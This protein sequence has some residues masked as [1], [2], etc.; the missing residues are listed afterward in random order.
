MEGDPQHD[1][2]MAGDELF[3]RWQQTTLI[4][5]P[6]VTGPISL[7]SSTMIAYIIINDWSHKRHHLYHRLL[8]AMSICDMIASTNASFSG[9]YIPKVYNRFGSHGNIATCEM[10]G[11]FMT[12]SISFAVLNMF[13][14]LFYMRVV[15][16]GWTP[17]VISRNH[18]SAINGRRWDCRKIPWFELS[19]YFLS[20][21]YP[22]AVAGAALYHESF[23]PMVTLPGWCYFSEVPYDCNKFDDVPCTRGA[24]YSFIQ[25]FG[26]VIPVGC[27][28]IGGTVAVTMVSRTVRKQCRTMIAR[29]GISSSSSQSLDV[30]TAGNAENSSNRT[31]DPP[32]R[33]DGNSSSDDSS[34]DTSRPPQSRLSTLSRIFGRHQPTP[35]PQPQSSFVNVGRVYKRLHEAA[36]QAWLYSLAF[37]IT[38]AV[39]ISQ[40]FTG[41]FMEAT[42]QNRLFFFTT[43]VLITTFGPLQ[44]AWNLLIYLRPYYRHVR[45]RDPHLSCWKVA[46]QAVSKSMQ[47]ESFP[48]RRA[49][50]LAAIRRFRIRSQNTTNSNAIRNATTIDNT[51][52]NE[53]TSRPGEE[54]SEH[55]QWNRR[56]EDEKRTSSRGDHVIDPNEFESFESDSESS[57]GDDHGDGDGDEDGDEE[58]IGTCETF[59]A[60]DDR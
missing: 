1:E 2:G 41:A 26:S 48:S 5:I 23:N 17:P 36:E 25:L 9:L 38:Y 13:L 35:P 44:G 40:A 52:N 8:L 7:F 14:C 54:R 56:S 59:P 28:V 55:L 22:L 57:D 34:S 6:Y 4:V 58:D 19:A 11:F 49:H 32:Q 10:A 39:A 53:A 29:Y 31:L 43:G 50:R 20:I 30:I 3:L 37:I 33:L 45:N 21:P 51:N 47:P 60:S 12:L 42:P 15:C 16:F 46:V 24:N 18:S 27:A